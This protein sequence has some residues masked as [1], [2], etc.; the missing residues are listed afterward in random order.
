MA[1]T[2]STILLVMFMPALNAIRQRSDDEIQTSAYN[3]R[4]YSDKVLADYKEQEK[5]DG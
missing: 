3:A 5:H 2:L 4:I 1:D